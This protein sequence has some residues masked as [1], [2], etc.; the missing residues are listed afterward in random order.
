MRLS[1]RAQEFA[2]R[3]YQLKAKQV[4]H[5]YQKQERE[6]RFHRLTDNDENSRLLKLLPKKLRARGEALLDCYFEAFEL[7]GKIPER[8]D[9]VEL[10][11]KLENIF[12]NGHGDF[13]GS[14]PI[15]VVFEIQALEKEMC[16]QM[17]L[18]AEKMALQQKRGTTM[19]KLK[20]RWS[21]LPKP[22]VPNTYRVAGI[23]DVAVSADDI[24]NAE[25]IGGDPW[26]ELCDSTTFGY[27][28]RQYTIGH[29]TPA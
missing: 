14:L 9:L 13:T 17:R 28:V 4:N 26:I 18:R 15:G 25:Q 24:R 5:E 7:D 6:I 22:E 10:D 23:G 27:A 1:K 16:E 11:K 20:I 21:Q 29:F 19:E 2:E 12:C 3:N 8:D